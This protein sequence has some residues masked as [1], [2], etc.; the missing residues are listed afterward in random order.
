MTAT[1][2]CTTSLTATPTALAADDSDSTEQLHRRRPGYEFH[3]ERL[4]Q[5]CAQQLPH[6]P[7]LQEFATSPL[8]TLFQTNVP[9]A[10][11]FG[12]VNRS[13]IRK[14]LM[15]SA[16]LSCRL[17]QVLQRFDNDIHDTTTTCTMTSP[18]TPT[19]PPTN[20]HRRRLVIWDLCCGKGFSSLWLAFNTFAD[21][22][23]EVTTTNGADCSNS[24][25]YCPRTRKIQIHMTDI[26]GDSDRSWL[27]DNPTLFGPKK[28]QDDNDDTGRLLTFHC[29]D[30]Y[31]KALEDEIRA[32]VVTDDTPPLLILVGIHTCGDLSRRVLELGRICGAQ[33]TLIN[34][35]CCVENVR[36]VKRRTGSFGYDTPRKARHFHGIVSVYQLW[37]WMLWGY[38]Q[39]QEQQQ[40]GGDEPMR[41]RIDLT[42]EPIMKTDKNIWLTVISSGSRH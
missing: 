33:A 40:Q 26:N 31:S 38:A 37:C 17:K 4:V 12:R 23:D 10:Q 8:A 15:E 36:L 24:S 39:S 27:H 1:T 13:R 6:H 21:D 11:S 28:E 35:C 29:L 20:A 42:C 3:M 9:L 5:E 14:E 19:T 16:A 41:N 18:T 32:S 22:D 25:S 30:I 34:P 2:T 7:F